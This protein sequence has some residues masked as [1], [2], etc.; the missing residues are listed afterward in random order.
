MTKGWLTDK[1]ISIQLLTLTLI[2]FCLLTVSLFLA[3]LILQLIGYDI[4]SNPA[5]VLDYKNP[6]NIPALEFMQ[7]VY[8]ISAFCLPPFV[9]TYLIAEQPLNYL[10][11]KSPTKSFNLLITVLLVIALLPAINTMGALNELVNFPD[12]LGLE[13]WLKASE[14]SAA[15]LTEV[16]LAMP[17]IGSLLFVLFMVAL[18]PAIGEELLFRGVLQPLIINKTRN[19]HIGIWVAAFVFSAIHL[20]FYT[21]LPRFIL[22]ALFGYMF[23]WSGNM[24]YPILG[25]FI[26][27]GSAVLLSY[28]VQQNMVSKE[29]EDIGSG[30]SMYLWGISSLVVGGILVYLFYKKEQSPPK[31]HSQDSAL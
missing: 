20:Q 3:Q 10:G 12:F 2:V 25:H 7:V 19:I 13:G 1:T 23:V 26:N 21:F 16:L 4:L 6:D 30:D 17:N 14:K 8:S 29:F 27:N 22:G 11:L 24:W 31:I 28:L 15:E 9:F 5:S 18:L